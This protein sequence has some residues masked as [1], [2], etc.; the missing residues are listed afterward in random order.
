MRGGFLTDSR[1][2]S[3]CPAGLL[4]RAVVGSSPPRCAVIMR[5]STSLT[6]MVT[7]EMEMGSASRHTEPHRTDS[8]AE[9][10]NKG[11]LNLRPTDSKMRRQ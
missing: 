5:G 9:N 10:K 11:K 3:Y 8:N 7:E 1:W 6:E 2:D 4:D